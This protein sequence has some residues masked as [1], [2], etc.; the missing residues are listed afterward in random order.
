[1]QKISVFFSGRTTK[2]GG[3][4]VNPL[5]LNKTTLSHERKK[6]TK[7]VWKETE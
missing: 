6:W 2:R 1:M 4:K 7:K 3:G 5:K